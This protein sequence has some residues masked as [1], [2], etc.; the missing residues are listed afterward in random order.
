MPSDSGFTARS[1]ATPD[2]STVP[3]SESV[4]GAR[5]WLEEQGFDSAPV[6]D[7]GR[8][9]GYVTLEALE[10]HDG[11]S[12]LETVM[13]PLTIDV[14]ISGDASFK[15][16]LDA[17]Y[18]KPFYYLGD[19]KRISGILTRADLN[20]EPVYRHLFTHLSRLE[21]ALRACI[22]RHAPDWQDTTPTLDP[23]TL[24]SIRDRRER[25]VKANIELDAIHY[26]QFSTL[27]KVI[28]ENEA[29][30]RACGFDADHQTSSR[31]ETV[32]EL[33]NDVAH[34]TPIIQNTNRGF[35]ESGRTITDLQE[36][37]E[38]VRTLQERLTA[39]TTE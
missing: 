6:V 38:L 31:L 10:E 39:V 2:P 11:D 33:R 9:V 16:V 22:T 12:I 18:E 25:A 35:L 19:R 30:W 8:P 36:A 28:S 4:E 15:T 29:C 34:S 27:K 32:V 1:I 3:A 23:D 24:D 13:S 26:A 14:H 37:Y 21:H 20:S 7:E 17:L 5:I